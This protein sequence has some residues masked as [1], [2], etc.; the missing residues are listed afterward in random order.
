MKHATE[1]KLNAVYSF[2]NV[3]NT[4]SITELMGDALIL[5]KHQGGGADVFN[6]LDLMQVSLSLGLG[7]NF[8][9]LFIH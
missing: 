8:A 5:A 6:C 9:I 4:M 1:K 2:Y 3:A 7:L